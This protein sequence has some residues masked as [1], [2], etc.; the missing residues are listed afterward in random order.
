MGEFKF[1]AG[2]PDGGG[3]RIEGGAYSVLPRYDIHTEEIFE[4]T[5]ILK[6]EALHVASTARIDSFVK[7]EGGQGVWIGECVHISSFCH[8]NV[9]GGEVWIGDH[10]GIASG[11]KVLG[12]T[13]T[14]DGESMS[15]ASPAAMQ[16]VKRLRTEIDDGAFVGVNAVIMPGVTV[17]Q[18]A[19]VAA[20]AVV[21][22]NVPAFEIWAG[23]PAKK[24][25]TR[26]HDERVVVVESPAL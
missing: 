26:E 3:V 6:P 17:G 8:I 23:V 22:R 20:G 1:I 18:G 12:G 10:V 19:V 4:P 7:I 15:A 24:I 5:V 14:M 9:G 11:A 16:R 2:N 25:G 13:N 21:T